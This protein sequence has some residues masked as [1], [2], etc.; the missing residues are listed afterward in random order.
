MKVDDILKDKLT[1]LG[2]EFVIKKTAEAVNEYNRVS[3][4]KKVIAVL[5]LTC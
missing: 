4:D 5:H 2:I 1:A 3:G